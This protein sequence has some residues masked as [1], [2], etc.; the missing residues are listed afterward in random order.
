MGAKKLILSDDLIRMP[1]FKTVLKSLGIDQDK[2]YKS[3]E[4][5]LTHD[6]VVVIKTEFYG[7]SE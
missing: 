4:I 6:D 7:E 3:I 5:K 2:S 1:E